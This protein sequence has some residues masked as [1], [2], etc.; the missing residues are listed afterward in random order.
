MKLNQGVII[1]LILAIFVSVVMAAKVEKSDDCDK[2]G[3]TR[4]RLSSS[5]QTGK[6]GRILTN[7]FS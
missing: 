5:L 7:V 1:I 2:C 6:L 3:P 4:V